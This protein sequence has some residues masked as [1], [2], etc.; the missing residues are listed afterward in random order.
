MKFLLLQLQLQQRLTKLGNRANIHP[1]LFSTP[2]LIIALVSSFI[3]DIQITLF[4]ALALSFSRFFGRCRF[5][6]NFLLIELFNSYLSS[7]FYFAKEIL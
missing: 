5:N 7:F 3:P 1:Y 2:G 6:F 4:L